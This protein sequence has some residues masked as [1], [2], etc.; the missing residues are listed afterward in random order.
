M[1]WFKVYQSDLQVEIYACTEAL[2][3]GAGVAHA[4]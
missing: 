4:V 2:V 3:H 1:N